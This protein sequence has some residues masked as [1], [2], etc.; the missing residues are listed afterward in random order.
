MLGEQ[1][2]KTNTPLQH[3]TEWLRQ[4]YGRRH[5]RHRRAWYPRV[6]PADRLAVPADPDDLRRL[7][8]T[9][10]SSYLP[11]AFTTNL[12]MLA[13]S[14][15]KIGLSATVNEFVNAQVVVL[16]VARSISAG[17]L[18][19]VDDKFIQAVRAK[20]AEHPIPLLRTRVG[21]AK[22]SDLLD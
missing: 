17:Q 2:N 18:D 15:N 9:T 12:A 14:A 11:A 10:A 7:F 22:L 20:L 5:Y 19:F 6:Q 8:T 16:S 21:D 13:H 3:A 1:D 4:P